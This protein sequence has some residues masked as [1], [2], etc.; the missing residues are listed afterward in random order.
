MERLEVIKAR[1]VSVGQLRDVVGAMRSLAAMRMQQAAEMLAG[2]RRYAHVIDQAVT[3]ALS[4]EDEPAAPPRRER[5]VGLIVFSAE[6]GFV[7]GYAESLSQAAVAIPAA[8]T[9]VVGTKGALSLAEQG[10]RADWVLPMASHAGGLAEVARRVADQVAERLAD[11]GVTHVE[12]VY[13]RVAEGT[14]WQVQHQALF[15]PALA[16][17]PDPGRDGR[18]PLHHLPAAQLL[19]R[20]VEERLLAELMLAAT[21]SLAA[22]NAAR[23]MA[24]TAAG[25]NIE[26]KLEDLGSQERILRQE[27][28][29]EELLDVVNGAELLF[30]GAAVTPRSS[31]PPG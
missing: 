11:G 9:L 12:T 1:I 23:L 26:R 28:I 8:V 10:R 7:G 25:D 29:T 27:Q 22:E 4:L 13:G 20:V 19:A 5:K 24:M 15:P 2:A 21:E 16:T 3:Q 17:A 30:A 18:A 31:A 6:H 14:R